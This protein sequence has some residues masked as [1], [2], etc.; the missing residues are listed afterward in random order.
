[1]GVMTNGHNPLHKCETGYDLS[2][3]LS[4]TKRNKRKNIKYDL[5]T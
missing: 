3:K 5:F 4:F 2:M 1:M